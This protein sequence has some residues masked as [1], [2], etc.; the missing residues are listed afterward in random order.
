VLRGIYVLFVGCVLAALANSAAY[1]S[2]PHE[3][4]GGSETDQALAYLLLAIVYMVVGLVVHSRFEELADGFVAGG[5][6][7]AVMAVAAG[8][9][10][11][12]EGLTFGVL[13]TALV[14]AILLGYFKF[15]R[16]R[17]LS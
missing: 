5:M 7:T 1:W 4:S 10:S 2:L 9:G 3:M 13:I 17:P 15:F 6:F 12:S 11:A 16:H 8:F 14:A